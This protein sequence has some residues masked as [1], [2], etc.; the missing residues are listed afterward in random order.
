MDIKAYIESG[1]IESYVLGLASP[2]EAA[3]V[4]LL[5][6]QYPAIKKAVDDFSNAIEKTG[7]ENIVTPPAELKNKIM[8]A[9]KDSADDENK[10]SA[11]PVIQLSNEKIETAKII[12]IW[13]YAAVASVILLVAST[14]L[15]FY[16]YNNYKTVSNQY[17]ALLIQ[18]NSLQANNDIYNARLKKYSESF[19]IIK[20]PDMEVV[21]MKGTAGRED[22]L[23]TIYWNIKTKDVFI[24]ANKMPKAPAGKQFQLWAIVNGTPVSAGV[25]GE[26]NDALCKMKNIPNAQAFAVTLEQQGGSPSPTLTEMYVIG[27]V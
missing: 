9:L 16:F 25:F 8:N 23:A 24:L 13:K 18:K 20:N 2:Q 6:T 15:N 21:E 11:T 22:N 14:A 12:S 26:C 10:T 19:S 7:F 5:C 17:Q 4:E 27:N 3:E 1:I